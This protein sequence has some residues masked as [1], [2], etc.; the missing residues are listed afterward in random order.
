MQATCDGCYTHQSV[1]SFISLGSSVFTTVDPRES[2]KMEM[3]YCHS[4]VCCLVFPSE[5]FV[6]VVVSKLFE[7]GRIVA[8]AF[9]LAVTSWNVLGESTYNCFSFHCQS[10]YQ[11]LM[12]ST[13]FMGN[14]RFRERLAPAL[15]GPWCLSH[16]CPQCDTVVCC[17]PLWGALSQCLHWL[18]HGVWAI[19]V[20]NLTLW[21][22]VFFCGVLHLCVCSACWPVLARSSQVLWHKGLIMIMIIIQKVDRMPSSTLWLRAWNNANRQNLFTSKYSIDFWNL[23]FTSN[24]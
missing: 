10:A 23:C 19:G 3:E 17:F 9:S 7:C 20:H 13:M 15:T 12:G 16:W 1:C 21:F 8:C 24:R 4:L 5:T 11:D 22:A 2:L 6:A 14:G 18:V